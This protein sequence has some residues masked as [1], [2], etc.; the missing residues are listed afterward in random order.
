MHADGSPL[1]SHRRQVTIYR[2]ERLV[3]RGLKKVEEEKLLVRDD[4]I[5]FYQFLPDKDAQFITLTVSI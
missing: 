1:I 4:G 2:N 5:V 3:N